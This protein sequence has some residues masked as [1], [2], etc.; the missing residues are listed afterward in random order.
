MDKR[1]N[2]Y[3]HN[4]YLLPPKP[5]SSFRRL[6]QGIQE[7]HRNYVLVPVDKAA[8]SIVVV[9]RLHY[10]NTIKQELKGTKAYKE[11]STDDK[12]VINSHSND[13]PY[14][15]AVNVKERQDKLPTIY[16]L[17]KLHKRPYK[18]RLIANSSTCTT[19]KLSKLLTYCLTTFKSRVIRYY[20]TVYERS[21]KNMLW[22]IKNS[23]EVLS[24]LKS[25]RFRVTS[26]STYDLSILYTTLPHNRIKE[27][28]LDLM[29][30]AFKMFYKNEGTL[31]FACSDKKAFSLLQ[32][33]EDIHFGLV[34]TD[35][36]PYRIFWILFTS[37]LVIS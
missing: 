8:N 34:I 35:V 5:K 17:P 3:S 2:F 18:V 27:K 16:W 29:E 9:C 12:T 21:R 6:K 26:L 28:L 22:S 4:T 25:R 13:L 36:T 31:Y 30:R 15:F 14:K 1:I 10:I 7:F 24:K 33:I 20:V 19:T 37:D 32:T 11:A 23:G